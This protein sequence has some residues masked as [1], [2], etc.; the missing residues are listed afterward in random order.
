[1]LATMAAPDVLWHDD[2]PMREVRRV[3]TADV[4]RKWNQPYYSPIRDARISEIAPEEAERIARLLE[5]NA[6]RVDLPL[7]YLMACLYQESRFDPR[8]YNRNLTLLDRRAT[9]FRTDWG[10]GHFSGNYLLSKPG[11]TGLSH[12]AAER[13]V[14]DP[15]WAIPVFADIMAGLAKRAAV[16]YPSRNK[17]WVATLAYN[18]G[19]RGM[20][21]AIRRGDTRHADRVMAHWRG[22]IRD[23]NAEGAER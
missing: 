14:M 6:E 18:K 17:Y 4:I 2:V 11:M 15:A 3:R 1:M 13:R 5:E 19:W 20:E 23:L 8:S 9:F 10:I 21:E 22:I 16:T 12:E 7:A